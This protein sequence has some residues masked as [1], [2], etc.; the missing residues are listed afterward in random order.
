MPEVYEAESLYDR[1]D[2]GAE[3]FFEYGFDRA[4]FQDYEKNNDLLQVELYDMADNVAAFG[5]FS[6]NRSP[7]AKPVA[8]G[9][10][11]QQY[12]DTVT[13]WQREYYAV[14]RFFGGS[15]TQDDVILDAARDIEAKIG[16]DRGTMPAAA[17]W[18]RLCRRF[19]ALPEV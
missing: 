16:P 6:A 15:G 5:I 8:L 13:F 2:G 9:A 19:N 1:I 14:V 10:A 17:R 7:R 3:I 11:G 12:R 18:G 4:V